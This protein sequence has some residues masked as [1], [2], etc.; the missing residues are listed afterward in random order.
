M[1]EV[2]V[3]PGNLAASAPQ[4]GDHGPLPAAALKPKSYEQWQKEVVRRAVQTEKLEL[5]HS[6]V[7][8]LVS[9]PGESERDFRIRLQTVAHEQR[10]AAVD[11]VRQKYATRHA[12]MSEQIRRAEQAVERETDQAREQKVQTAVSFGATV[13]GVLLG[14]KTVSTSTLGRATTAARGAGRA[15]RQTQDVARANETLQAKRAQ[16]QELEEK[17]RAEA[18][19]AASTIDPATARLETIVIK[20]KRTDATVEAAV[21]VWHPN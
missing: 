18:D 20:P 2:D 17:I 6:P 14:R 13:I 19:V 9:S 11:R 16:L 10:D 5:L 3:R 1:K 21:L 7:L 12:S 8:R 4:A 15:A